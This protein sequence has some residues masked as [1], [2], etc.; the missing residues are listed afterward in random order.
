MDKL[1]RLQAG[2]L[3][4]HQGEHGI[5]HH[6]PVVGGQHILAAL[7]EDGVE[8]VAADV[9]GHGIG[10]GVER[11]LAQIG[12]GVDV[13]HDAAGGGVVLEIPEHLVHLVHVPLGIVVLHAQL[14]AVSL[15]DGAVLVRP[16]V[17]DPGAQV[18]H[19]V[20]LLLPDPQQ[21]VD[22]GLPVGAPQGQDR[23][24]LGQIVAVHNA[25][26]LDGMGRR[27]VLPAGS[28]LPIGVPDAVRQNIPAVLNEDLIGF[29]HAQHLTSQKCPHCN[30]GT[31][32]CPRE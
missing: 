27:A 12:K 5:L 19:V 3:G 9:E 18:V 10:A 21:L 8:L 26:F 25:E 29:A 30:T 2:D 7:V 32:I 22:G 20:A 28:H 24:F 14:I 6:V 11:H 31:G 1:A 23:E 17:P 16:G 4:H 13:G 15:A